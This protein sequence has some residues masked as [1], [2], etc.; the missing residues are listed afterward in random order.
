[1]L[2][3]DSDVHRGLKAVVIMSLIVEKQDSGSGSG[4]GE[5]DLE[6]PIAWEERTTTD[7]LQ[8]VLQ[9]WQL[10]TQLCGSLCWFILFVG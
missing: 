6:Q 2:T 4:I 1:M 8:K 5:T 9:L 3:V 10:G 7:K